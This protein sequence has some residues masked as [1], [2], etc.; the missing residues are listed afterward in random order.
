ML[1]CTFRK[2]SCASW[3]NRDCMIQTTQLFCQK[4]RKKCIREHYSSS[5]S[6]EQ[7]TIQSAGRHPREPRIPHYSV[8]RVTSTVREDPKGNRNTSRR[9]SVDVE[10]VEADALLF[11]KSAFDRQYSKKQ[12]LM[13]GWRF[14]ERWMHDI[15]EQKYDEINERLRFIESKTGVCLCPFRTRCALVHLWCEEPM[16][17]KEPINRRQWFDP[18]QDAHRTVAA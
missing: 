10:G 3:R 5:D 4:S 16:M 18:E 12:N 13:Y 2:I 1:T 14:Q 11:Q 9:A 15:S 8:S 7:F 6:P 17:Y